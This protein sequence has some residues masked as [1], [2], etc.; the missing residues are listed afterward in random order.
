MGK[1]KRFNRYDSAVAESRKL[2]QAYGQSRQDLSIKSFRSM[3]KEPPITTKLRGT[4]TGDGEFLTVS[5]AADQT[6]N[7]AANDHIE[8]DTKDEDGGIFLQTGSGQADGI[9]ELLSGKKYILSAQLRPEFSG[10]TGQLVIAWYDRTN[11]AEIGSRAIYESQTHASHNANQP[12]GE[13]TVTPDTNIDVEVRIIAVTALT[14]LANEYCTASIYE[15]SLGGFGAGASEASASVTFPITPTI[16]DESD[17]WSSPVT[18]DLSLTTAH[19]TKF[20]LD[21]DLTLVFSN[22]PSS[23]TQIEFEIEFVQ[24]GT[25][26]R[27]ITFPASVAEN[28]TISSGANSTTIVTCRTND[29]GTTYHVIPALRGSINLGG[30]FADQQLSN[31]SSVAINTSLISDGDNIDDLGSATNEWKDLYLDGVAN[32]DTIAATTMSG[33]IAFASNNATGLGFISSDATVPSTGFLRMGNGEFIAWEA[34]PAGTDGLI[35]Y[36]NLERFQFAGAGAL[37]AASGESIS[38]GVAGSPWNSLF[39]DSIDMGSANDPNI[40]NADLGSTCT[41]RAVIVTTSGLSYNDGVKQTF[42]PNA[43]N[44]GLN[45]GSHTAEPSSPVAGDIIYDSTA[46]QFKGYDGAWKDLGAGTQT[47]WASNIDGA[48]F[49]LSN[50]GDLELDKTGSQRTITIQR[51]EA[52]ADDTAIGEIKFKALDGVPALEDYGNIIVAMESDAAG[53]EDGSMFFETAAGGTHRTCW[54]SFNDAQSQV[55]NF[56]H[57]VSFLGG[58]VISIFDSTDAESI[59]ISK[60]LTQGTVQSPDKLV[61]QIGADGQLEIDDGAVYPTTDNDVDL[62]KSGQE[63]KDLFIDGTANIDALSNSVA[64]DIDTDLNFTGIATVDYV[65]TGSAS[66]GSG[67]TLPGNVEG[68]IVIK[69]AGVARRVAFYPA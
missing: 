36:N 25:G 69:V 18:I 12:L 21:T 67:G 50:V 49:N 23:G 27:K 44:A 40:L 13:I 68:F 6:A 20:T 30:S 47:P 35:T 33:D 8:F 42:N 2:S 46:G 62:G 5:L 41:L 54:L 28:V 34:S 53:S 14:A 37:V 58:N 9:F 7:I 3:P 57:P 52:L 24:D 64:I 29:N 16:K 51:N 63:F 10:A 59:S 1:A 17:T 55:V 43:T 65:S 4:G 31:L 15:I 45:V 38:L 39:V 32:I 48:T 26:G 11:S 22:P 61:F 19:M 60:T 56:F 66:S